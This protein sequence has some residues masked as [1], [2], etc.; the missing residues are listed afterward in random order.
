[1][2]AIFSQLDLKITTDVN[3]KKVN[4]LDVTFDLSTGIYKP[5]TKP[6]NTILYVNRLSNHPPTVLKNIPENVNKRLC[7]ISC[8]EKVFQEAAG[9]YQKAL[10]D[11][12]Y[13][14][15]L[16]YKNYVGGEGESRVKPK[17][18]P[19]NITWFNPPFSLNVSTN[20]GRKFLNIIK[21]CFPKS[22][23]L[24]KIIN[25]NTVKVSYRCMPN[26]K[27]LI[28]RHNSKVAN[29]AN[30]PPPIPPCKCG[31][32]RPP[33]PLHG[34]CKD[35]SLVYR[36]TVVRGDNGQVET[37]TGM[38][39]GTFKKRWDRHNFDFRHETEEGATKLSGYIWKL[40]KRNIPYSISWE[41][42]KNSRVFNPVNKKCKLCL[43]EKYQIM[44][45]REG[46]SLN[47]RKELFTT[48][49]HRKQK[50]LQN[51]K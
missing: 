38:T 24:H 8:N 21:E 22:N 51:Y 34:Q 7:S 50:L 16:K 41:K 20:V 9:P 14:F 28:S 3:H 29:E 27:S 42:I 25:K 5:Y 31:G 17:N 11:S 30:P 19:R 13:D 49:R 43:N 23:P 12:G 6:N 45:H 40:K 1:M 44:F 32:N 15:E 4:F 47:S 39:G 48:C 18:R 26:M 2:C 33:C 37:Y 10:K 35:S 46:A 36:A